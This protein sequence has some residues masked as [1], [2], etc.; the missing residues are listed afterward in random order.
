MAMLPSS[1]PPS[2]LQQFSKQFP[3]AFSPIVIFTARQ[4]QSRPLLSFSTRA[5]DPETNASSDTTEEASAA[6]ADDDDKF[7]SRLAQV[8]Y[9]YRSGTGK[10]AEVRKGKRSKKG[11][12]GGVFLPPI[13]LKE[14]VSGRLKVDFGFSPYTERINGSLAALG[15][16]ALLLVELASGKSVINYHTPA[17]IFV[18]IYFVAAVSTLYIKYEK[19]RISIWPQS[20]KKS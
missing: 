13:P 10:K 18:Q 16:A 2:S 17:I 5:V 20:P 7:E 8:R 15:L 9:R 12:G 11:S 1:S 19:E 14:P 6:A 4:Q 3:A